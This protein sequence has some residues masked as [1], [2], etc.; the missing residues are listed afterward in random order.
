MLSSK[1]TELNMEE[2]SSCSGSRMSELQILY[3]EI[4]NSL[5]S[6]PTREQD[7]ED[8]QFDMS[9]LEKNQEVLSAGNL[10]TSIE[11]FASVIPN[12][13]LLG[14]LLEH[15]C[16]VYE[17]DPIRSR[18]LFKVIGQRL[19]TM[20]LVSPLAVS[21]EFS[22][23]RL[24]H[25]R[26]FTELLH[27]ASSSLFPQSQQLLSADALVLPA[28]LKEGL[29]QAQTSRYLSEFEE[30]GRLGKGAYGK[31][32]KVI[33]KLDGQSY[34]VKKILI[35][36]VSRNDCMKVLREVKMLSSLQ[37][38]CVVGYHTAWMEHV[39]PPAY[40]NSHLPALESPAPQFSGDE[41][42]GC[43]SNG[44]SI[45]FQS[46]SW[47]QSDPASR[48]KDAPGTLPPITALLP[49]S[50]SCPKLVRRLPESYV[51][52]V[53]LGQKAAAAVAA[54]AC[55]ALAWDGSALERDDWSGSSGTDRQPEPGVDPAGQQPDDKIWLKEVQFHL[56]LYIQ[57]QL[58]ER[59]LKDWI[60]ERNSRPSEELSSKCPYALVD[61][62][63]T[64]CLLRKTLEGVE[65]IH[66]KGMMHRDLKPPNIF[67]HGQDSQV[68]IGD[69]GLAC[70]DILV[71]DQDPLP[72]ASNINGSQHTAGVGTFV[73]AAPEQLEG[74]Y[75][76][77]KSDMY[78]I[79]VLALEL[80]Q[81]F[82]T[83]ME[84]VRTLENLREGTVPDS[85]SYR[86]PILA[87]YVTQLTSKDPGVRPTASQLLQS[88]LFNSKD[89]VIHGLQR[90]VE[91]QKE[92]I[93]VLRRQ[94]SALQISQ[95]SPGG[96]DNNTGH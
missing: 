3:Q 18:M 86:W 52:C 64:L 14:S 55:P 89:V 56:M 96:S 57:M 59:S 44:S 28:R 75:Y 84:R 6:L 61:V 40:P 33:N 23:V 92:E 47:V 45:V 4:D 37:H 34:A 10:Y 13:L 2:C 25:N 71:N 46:G 94:I 74:S 26:A 7:D 41:S 30:I 80:F 82:G 22:T 79:G 39:Q 8:V 19:T 93:S 68:R 66:S 91:E 50:S 21:D 77:S 53:F 67:L 85:F 1:Y 11:E 27:A 72:S 49:S 81:P 9:D 87:K 16:F 36:N 76:D 15:L 78:S 73:Y 95:S 70:K 42:P 54:K 35:K 88:E 83:E 48:G 60:S 51:P 32:F 63:H 58:C 31:V 43:S 69:F 20:N 29:F 38:V 90:R 65:Y 62:E 24:Q 12:H 5:F 17:S